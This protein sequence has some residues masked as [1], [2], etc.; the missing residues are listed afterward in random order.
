MI[1]ALY[2]KCIKFEK[3][4]SISVEKNTDPTLSELSELKSFDARI[5]FAKEHWKLLGEGSSRTAFEIDEKLIIKIAHNDKGIAQNLV[6][7][8]PS[9][10]TDCVIQ[11]VVADGKGKWI[12]FE[13][14]ERLTKKDFKKI[15]G[16][17]FDSFMNALFYAMNNESDKWSKPREFNEIKKNSL[18]RCVA[19]LVFENQLLIGDIS[20]ASTWGMLN[21][22]PIIRDAGLDKETYNKFYDD[23]SSTSSTIKT[24]E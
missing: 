15:V 20:K 12:I 2:E 8:Q 18:F 23:D 24:S 5:E 10:Q 17:G 22:K 14:S 19:N 13:N 6:E 4:A 21:G 9:V 11:A 3:A 16:F 1:K 7:M